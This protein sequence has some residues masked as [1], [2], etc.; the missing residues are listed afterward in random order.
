MKEVDLIGCETIAID[1]TKSRAHN[2]KKANFNQK[3]IDKHLA[4]IETK[5]QEYLNALEEND[6][7]DNPAKI[8]N[9]QQKIDRLKGNKLR[10]ELLEENL[11]VS[12]QPHPSSKERTDEVNKHYR[13][14]CQSF[15]GVRSSGRDFIQ[16]LSRSGC[17][18]QFSGSYPHHQSP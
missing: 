3:K 11:K 8:Q 6:A 10:Y 15:V 1:G 16:Y 9:I 5:T 4:Y 2:S 18:A 13:Q 14:R 12:G 17:Q 7:K